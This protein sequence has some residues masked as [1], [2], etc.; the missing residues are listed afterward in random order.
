M[1]GRRVTAAAT[2]AIAAL[3]LAACSGGGT[4]A[5]PS[6][7]PASPGE[8]PTAGAVNVT[9][10]EWAVEP[11]ETT[12]P[13][14]DVTFTVTNEGPDYSHDFQVIKTDLAPDSLPTAKNGSFYEEGNGFK[15][16][17]GFGEMDV[18]DQQTFTLTLP[19]GAYALICNSVPKESV[20]STEAHYAMGMHTAFTVS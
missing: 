8:G 4:T 3:I 2:A 10:H 1:R 16:I 7:A 19:P 12:A 5:T 9:L 14:G 6:V 20:G 13:A 15:F 11:S 17:G 18:G